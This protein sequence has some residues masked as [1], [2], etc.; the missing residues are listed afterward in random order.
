MSL[1]RSLDFC[2]WRRLRFRVCIEKASRQS[3]FVFGMIDNSNDD[4]PEGAQSFLAVARTPGQKIVLRSLIQNLI[5]PTIKV[6]L[7]AQRSA[8]GIT[9]QSIERVL[10]RRTFAQR[11]SLQT[12]LLI[13]WDVVC[14]I[15][16]ARK[17]ASRVNRVNHDTRT[18]SCVRDL[19]QFVT[20]AGIAR[21]RIQ[22][23]T[24]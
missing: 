13:E 21:T 3:H 4:I 14:R 11:S 12:V 2:D 24:V 20:R 17:Q 19:F 23:K 5:D 7:V 6:V 10:H 9:R 1:C 18:Q 16:L 22:Q 8:A 15:K